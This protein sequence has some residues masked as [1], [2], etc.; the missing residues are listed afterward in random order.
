MKTKEFLA[1]AIIAIATLFFDLGCGINNTAKPSAAISATRATTVQVSQKPAKKFDIDTATCNCLRGRTLK[2]TAKDNGKRVKMVSGETPVL[3]VQGKNGKLPF[4][5]LNNNI[6]SDMIVAS[7]SHQDKNGL[8]EHLTPGW[9]AVAPYTG[10]SNI[11]IGNPDEKTYN[12][13]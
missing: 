2:L 6:Y 9:T 5:Y 10:T 3:D 4:L 12:S 1:L 7:I 11:E 13:S 8:H